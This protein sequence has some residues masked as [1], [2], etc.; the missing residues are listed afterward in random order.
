MKFVEEAKTELTKS[1]TTKTDSKTGET[2]AER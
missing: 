1:K 2:V